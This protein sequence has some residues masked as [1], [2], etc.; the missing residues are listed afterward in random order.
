MGKKVEQRLRRS[1][2]FNLARDLI[3]IRWFASLSNY[4]IESSFSP[5]HCSFCFGVSFFVN[6]KR[7][8]GSHSY[9]FSVS[10]GKTLP[11]A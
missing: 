7:T 5:S 9:T 11:L 6:Q 4:T 3:I 10:K 2:L 8:S 1:S